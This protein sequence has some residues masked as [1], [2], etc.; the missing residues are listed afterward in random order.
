MKNLLLLFVLIPLLSNSQIITTFA[1]NGIGGH[2]GDGGPATAAEVNNPGGLAFDGSGNVFFSGFYDNNIRKVSASGIIST[3]CGT[4]IAGYSGDGGQATDAQLSGPTK[5]YMDATGDLYIADQ[6]N[7]CIRKVSPAGIIS[8]FAGT[9]LAGYNGDGISATTAQLNRPT[10]ITKD[11]AGNFYI[12]DYINHRVRIVSPAGIINTIAGDGVPGF[13]GDGGSATDASLNEPFG[14]TLDTSGNVF[15]SDQA[16]NRIREVSSA[17]IISTIA[18]NGIGGYAGDGGPAT[19]AQ[20]NNPSSLAI[21]N[22]GNFYISD[23]ENFR[24]RAIA[25]SGIITTFCG[26]GTAGFGGDG[27]PASSAML[28]HSNEIEFD[29]SWNLFICDNT[30]NRVRKISVSCNNSITTQPQNDT[31]FA[32]DTAKYSVV[33]TMSAPSYQ[34]QENPGTGF[35][36]LINVWPYSGVNTD[37]LTIQDASHLLNA[38]YYRCIINS[39]SSHC[40]DTSS[41]AILII[42]SGVGVGELQTAQVRIFPDPAHDRLTIS[43]PGNNGFGKVELYNAI[44][45]QYLEQIITGST[46]DLNIS[47]LAAGMYIVKVVVGGQTIVRKVLKY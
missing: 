2:T 27:G 16:N 38:T 11:G 46:A 40:P 29:G 35:A 12:A 30:N 41:P 1:G 15:I 3:I 14:V 25:P 9:G 24:I 26:N 22:A 5:I 19:D 6:Y 17:G 37:T 10:G 31:V 43:I 4:G 20:L 18:G 33:T 47:Q 28:N 21:D 45:Q 42:K 39:E 8:T 7:N 44:G 13:S 36:S 34:W 23:Q 32:G